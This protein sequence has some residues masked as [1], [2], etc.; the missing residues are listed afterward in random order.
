M[1]LQALDL[2]TRQRYKDFC[3]SDTS[4]LCIFCF[5]I[6]YIYSSHS[7]NLI[8]PDFFPWLNLYSILWSRKSVFPLQLYFSCRKFSLAFTSL[9][10][11]L[12]SF[13]NFV[14]LTKKVFMFLHQMSFQ[15]LSFFSFHLSTYICV[16]CNFFKLVFS[17]SLH[18]SF[19]VC[20]FFFKSFLFLC[21]ALS[22]CSVCR[23][24]FSLSLFCP[25]SF[26]TASWVGT[27][28]EVMCLSGLAQPW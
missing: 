7:K 14:F 6:P 26:W 16:P 28:L 13:Q 21:L 12:N 19:C 10:L 27:V 5:K 8:V 2:N 20:H 1:L 17:F 24:L 15:I 18:L 4:V 25:P 11:K 3:N 23:C 22:F 9:L